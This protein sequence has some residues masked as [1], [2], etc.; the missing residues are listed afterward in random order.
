MLRQKSL[1][2]SVRSTTRPQVI[3]AIIVVVIV[4][5][6]VIVAVV[7]ARCRTTSSSSEPARELSWSPARPPQLDCPWLPSCWPGHPQAVLS[8]RCSCPALRC[9]PSGSSSAR[10]GRRSAPCVCSGSPAELIRLSRN[11]T[12]RC[13]VKKNAHMVRA[14]NNAGKPSNRSQS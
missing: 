5:V 1:A 11:Q 2:L 12:L 3:S 10:P 7:A 4:I 9:G 6:I 8:G 13:H 14:L